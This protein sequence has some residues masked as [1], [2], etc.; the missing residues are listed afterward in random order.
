MA[1]H[2]SRTEWE[3]V[4]SWYSDSSHPIYFN[5]LHRDSKRHR[6]QIKLK[7]DLSIASLHAINTSEL[8]P[9][10]HGS[11]FS[12]GY[13]ICEDT[14]V[15]WRYDVEYIRDWYPLRVV[16]PT[17]SRTAVLQPR[18]YYLFKFKFLTLMFVLYCRQVFEKLS[19]AGWTLDLDVSRVTF[20]FSRITEAITSSYYGCTYHF[21]R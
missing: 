1:H 11:T 16:F 2:P 9:Y 13:R 14:L 18:C 17:S 20:K 21:T 4:S 8:F 7:P 12:Q 5:M 10:D 19:L 3:M 15:S 6:F